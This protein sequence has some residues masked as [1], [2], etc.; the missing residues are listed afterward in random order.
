M[1]HDLGN[2]QQTADAAIDAAQSSLPEIADQL[3]A[4]N[5]SAHGFAE[6]GGGIEG[7]SA[8]LNYP[9]EGAMSGPKPGQKEL[10]QAMVNA[11]CTDITTRGGDMWGAP[12]M[13][14]KHSA[15]ARR[16]YEDL[17]GL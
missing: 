11:G 8:T 4:T 15:S 1:T 16:R 3:S 7:N 12:M 10:E 6:S 13:L 17:G 14:L 5:T 9:V 2:I